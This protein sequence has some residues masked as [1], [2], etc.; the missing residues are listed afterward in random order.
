MVRFLTKIMTDNFFFFLE[1]KL[2]FINQS[3]IASE[4]I[5]FHGIL[6][7]NEK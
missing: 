7:M 4:L 2:V 1:N 5:A 6:K 3:Y